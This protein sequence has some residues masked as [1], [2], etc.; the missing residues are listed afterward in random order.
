MSSVT[1]WNPFREFDDLFVNLAGLPTNDTRAAAR[2]EWLPPVDISES[3]EAY[4]IEMELPAIDMKDINVQVKDGV[5]TV[6]GERNR[7][8]QGEGVTRHRLERRYGS[9]SRS[10]RLPEDVQVEGISAKAKNGV[11]ALT[12]AKR[13]EVTPQRIE[14]EVH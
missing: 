10:F 1:R 13:E 8:V 4:L 12:L 2:S 6:N 5:L 11:L 3:A 14:V 7:T 9:F